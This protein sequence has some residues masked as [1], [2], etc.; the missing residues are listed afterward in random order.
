MPKNKIKLTAERFRL[1]PQ[2]FQS[3]KKYYKTAT[4]EKKWLKYFI[5]VKHI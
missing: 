5:R 2:L 1:A 3:P 4:P